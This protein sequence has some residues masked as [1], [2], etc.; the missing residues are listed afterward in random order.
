MTNFS[1]SFRVTE[2]VL[3]ANSGF[4]FRFKPPRFGLLESSLISPSSRELQPSPTSPLSL[5]SSLA[6]ELTT[7]L[8]PLR[9]LPP[10]SGVLEAKSASTFRFSPLCGV[11]ESS[12][13]N[14]SLQRGNCLCSHAFLLFLASSSLNL[15][16]RSLSYA[17]RPSR[18][19]LGFCRTCVVCVPSSKTCMKSVAPR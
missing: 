6:G 8:S 11:L 7:D 1:P 4:I 12:L 13:C 10:R 17:V 2:N 3:E 9:R 5:I 15:S 18:P 14:L 19:I 16:F